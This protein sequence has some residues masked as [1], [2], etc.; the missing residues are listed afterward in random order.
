ME[1]FESVTR[2]IC[3]SCWSEDFTKSTPSEFDGLILVDCECLKCETEFT[4]WFQYQNTSFIINDTY[5]D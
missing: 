1:I 2:D 3:P 5:L 4:M